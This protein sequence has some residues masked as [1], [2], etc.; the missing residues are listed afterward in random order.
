L[1]VSQGVLGGLAFTVAH[2][3][4]HGPGPLDATL[5]AALLVPMFYMH[6]SCSHLAHHLKARLNPVQT[7]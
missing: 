4:L 5:S 2:E 6:W 3:L 7:F 1:I